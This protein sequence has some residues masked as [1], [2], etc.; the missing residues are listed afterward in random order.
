MPRG[1]G[2]EAAGVTALFAWLRNGHPEA[3][4]PGRQSLA[5]KGTS[6]PPRSPSANSSTHV[7]QGFPHALRC[8]TARDPGFARVHGQDGTLHRGLSCRPQGP[9]R[10]VTCRLGRPRAQVPDCS[11]TPSARAARRLGRC[12]MVEVQR[13]VEYQLADRWVV[14][15]TQSADHRYRPPDPRLRSCDVLLLPVFVL[16]YCQP[17]CQPNLL[18]GARFCSDP[19]RSAPQKANKHGFYW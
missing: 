6:T 16:P 4:R 10:G 18:H 14:C 5:R 8:R 11:F 2:A 3:A 13:D 9:R 19:R 15:G 1:P 17:Y 7:E 12:R